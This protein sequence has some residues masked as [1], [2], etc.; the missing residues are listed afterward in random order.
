[1]NIL[2]P[3]AKGFEE[4]EAVTIVDVLRRADLKVVTAGLSEI[5]VEGSRGIEVIADTLFRDINPD[6]FDAIVLPGGSPG[7]VN[8]SNSNRLLDI[9]RKFN[10][11]KKMIAA[12]CAGP[13]V[14]AKAGIIGNRDVTVFPGLEKEVPKY[15]NEEVVCS[16]NIITSKG[17]GTAMKFALKIVEIFLGKSKMEEIKEQL[18]FSNI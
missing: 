2:V 16:D 9:L 11:E 18:V 17:A 7:Y 8:L 12:I 1:M 5:N 3:L 6:E 15:V 10:S 4:I 14:L 13:I